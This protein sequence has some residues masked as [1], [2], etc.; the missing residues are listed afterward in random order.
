MRGRVEVHAVALEAS[1]AELRRVARVLDACERTRARSYAHAH[2]ARRFV[3]ARAA[4]RALLARRLGVEPR[5]LRLESGARGRPR[6]APCHGAALV[7]SASR[8]GELALI[9]LAGAGALGVDVE[10][11]DPRGDEAAVAASFFPA[12]VCEAWSALPEARRASAF[13]EHW[14][15]TEAYVKAAG[16]GFPA[17]PGPV[18]CE[19]LAAGGDLRAFPL[20]LGA[21]YAAALVAP[22]G[23]REVVLRRHA[24]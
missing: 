2:D 22:R 4:L 7:F 11:V 5:A 19:R 24:P 8:S 10:R 3:V 1:A 13:F 20:A 16:D 15:R 18:R 12:P 17:R 21:G 6:L 9:A 14:T 23:T